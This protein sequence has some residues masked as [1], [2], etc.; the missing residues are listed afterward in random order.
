MKKAV[1]GG[2]VIVLSILM[3]W[4]GFQIYSYYADK[5]G[6]ENAFQSLQLQINTSEPPSEQPSTELAPTADPL[7]TEPTEPA[8]TPNDQYGTLFAQNADMIG[9]IAIAGTDI[10]YPVMQTPDNSDYY[11][12]RN[13]DGEYSSHGVPYVDAT[14]SIDPPSDNITVYGHHMNDGTMFA[15]LDHYTEKSFFEAHPYIAFDTRA[16]FGTYQIIA[17]FKVN[18]GEFAFDRMVDAGSEAEFDEY[19]RLCKSLAFYDTGISASYGDALLTLATCEYTLKDGRLVV[20]AKRV[21]A[22]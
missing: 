16:G 8:W 5:R 12:K 6:S 7:P 17:V 14:C 20:L 2:A 21:V 18:A 11:L 1:F 15:D 3:L 19:V 22:Q 4:S 9:W 13:F 10:S